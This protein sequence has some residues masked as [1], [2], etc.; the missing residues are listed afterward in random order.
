MILAMKNVDKIFFSLIIIVILALIA[1]YVIAYF[2]NQKKKPSFV[3]G[4]GPTQGKV[5]EDKKEEEAVDNTPK[6]E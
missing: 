4:Q 2:I 6:Q 1:A 3:V 5:E